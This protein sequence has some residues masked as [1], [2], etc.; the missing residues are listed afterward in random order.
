VAA[1]REQLLGY[2]AALLANEP[3]Q[4]VRL[5]FITAQGRF[6]ELDPDTP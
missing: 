5:A 2:R 1:H 3:T 4:P 6:I